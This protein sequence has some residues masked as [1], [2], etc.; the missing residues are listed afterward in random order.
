[1]TGDGGLVEVQAT[2]ERT[3]LSR[4]HL[5]DLLV[6]AAGGIEELRALQAQAVAGP[7]S[8]RLSSAAGH[9]RARVSRPC[10]PQ[11]AQA[12]GVRTAAGGGL[13]RRRAPARRRSSC[14]PRTGAT[15]ADNA[16][17]KARTAAAETGRIAIAD[18]SGIEAAALGG[19][20]GVHSARYAGGVGHRSGEPRQAARRGSRRQRPALRLRAGLRGPGRGGRAALLRLLHRPARR[21]SRAVPAGSATTRRSSPTAR[22]RAARWP[23]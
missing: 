19:R 15:F 11:P 1:M 22:V 10:D 3:P 20:P 13:D 18:D 9:E 2:A 6:L 17:P 23:S 21:R 4:A 5:D 16:L 8:H 14:R 12:A 7:P